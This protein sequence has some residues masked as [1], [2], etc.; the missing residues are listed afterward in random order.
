VLREL[1]NRERQSPT[2]L[3]SFIAVP[4]F[5]LKGER[6]FQVLLMRCRKGIEFSAVAPTVH[7]AFF[8][9]GSVDM[10]PLHLRALAAIAQVVQDPSFEKS[11]LSASTT[12]E[13]RRLVRYGKRKRNE[14]P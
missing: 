1:R 8:L 5:I 13:L 4:H 10:R 12:E 14:N 3:N 2:A 9:A 7:F 11:W 6:Q